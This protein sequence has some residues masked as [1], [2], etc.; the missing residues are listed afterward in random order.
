MDEQQPPRPVPYVVLNEAGEVVNVTMWDGASAWHS[1]EGLTVLLEADWPARQ[2][3][4]KP[5]S[6]Q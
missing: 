4:S 3:P 6:V 2:A 5:G 1:G